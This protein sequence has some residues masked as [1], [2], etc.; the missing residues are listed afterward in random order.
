MLGFVG[1]LHPATGRIAG[2]AAF[3]IDLPHVAC[4]FVTTFHATARFGQAVLQA[5]RRKADTAGCQH[6]GHE[7]RYY[8]SMRIGHNHIPPT[9]T[10]HNLSAFPN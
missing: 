3:C 8:G 4:G 7:R 5:G 9:I 6:D 2:A 1:R 10:S